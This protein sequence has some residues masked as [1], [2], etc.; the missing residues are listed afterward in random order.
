M[1]LIFNDICVNPEPH[2]ERAAYEVSNS[3]H[4]TA[5]S[6]IVSKELVK[7]LIVYVLITQRPKLRTWLSHLRCLYG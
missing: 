1:A 6:V 4:L 5:Q 7:L 2:I 3:F